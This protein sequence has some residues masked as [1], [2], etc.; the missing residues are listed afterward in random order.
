CK[1]FLSVIDSKYLPHFQKTIDWINGNIMIEKLPLIAEMNS[2]YSFSVQPKLEYYLRKIDNKKIPY[3][4]GQFYFTCKIFAFI[5]PFADTDNIDF[6]VQS[7]FDVFWKTFKHFDK[8]KGWTFN[9]YSNNN[10]REFGINLNFK[11]KN[12]KD[13]I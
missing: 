7:D 9:N 13:T 4:V 8:S 10:A 5:I 11:R 3:A 2:Y 12:E 1:Y 6:T